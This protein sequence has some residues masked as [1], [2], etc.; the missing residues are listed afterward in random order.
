MLKTAAGLSAVLATTLMMSGAAFAAD[1]I[2]A[3]DEPMMAAPASP[4]IYVQLLGGAVAGLDMSFYEGA[5]EY[6]YS[7]DNGY[8]VAA[9]VGIV[10]MD[11]LAIE[12][13]VLHSSRGFSEYDGDTQDNTSLM[14]NAK[15]SVALNDTFSLYGA[16]GVG[17]ILSTNNQSKGSSDDY[18]GAGYQL[19]AGAS[20]KV[21]ESISLVGEVR[22]QDGFSKLELDGDDYYTVDG[23]TVTVLAGVKFDF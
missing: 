3:P 11:G 22:Y 18:S 4:S 14:L 8:A 2:I 15:G 12:V 6:P 21:A 20:A 16:V 17:F 10:V 1:L 19:I 23:K 13:D 9:T 5:S 7:M